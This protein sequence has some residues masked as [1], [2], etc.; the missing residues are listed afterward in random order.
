MPELKL[1]HV[2]VLCSW[3]CLCFFFSKR[4][5]YMLLLKSSFSTVGRGFPFTG[6]TICEPPCSPPV[7]SLT[8]V[9]GLFSGVIKCWTSKNLFGYTSFIFFKPK[10]NHNKDRIRNKIMHWQRIYKI[11]PVGQVVL[12]KNI[13]KLASVVCN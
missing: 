9:G 10:S 3:L 12:S 5:T 1:I 6:V 13:R 11:L 4:R 7:L 8:G 2:N